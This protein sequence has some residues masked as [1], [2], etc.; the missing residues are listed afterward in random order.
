MDIDI[1]S[2]ILLLVAGAVSNCPVACSLF[3][4]CSLA[5]VAVLVFVAKHSNTEFSLS[6]RPKCV[7]PRLGTQKR[8]RLAKGEA[9]GRVGGGLG[10]SCY[11]W[12]WSYDH[13]PS[14]P[15]SAGTEHVGFLLTRRTMLAPNEREAP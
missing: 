14:H 11:A 13:R 10:Y 3:V 15:Y 2:S 4:A 1:Y 12:P 7:A 5:S 9:L 6:F 8:A